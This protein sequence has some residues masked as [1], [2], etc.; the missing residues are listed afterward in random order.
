MVYLLWAKRAETNGKDLRNCPGGSWR[1][2]GTGS[3][4]KRDKRK[5]FLQEENKS[6]N[7]EEPE[8]FPKEIGSYGK[9]NYLVK[10]N[11]RN[12]NYSNNINY[13]ERTN[14]QNLID[15]YRNK[16]HAFENSFYKTVIL[17]SNLTYSFIYFENSNS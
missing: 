2:A 5:E 14:L 4:G 1:T 8:T 17:I 11:I 12:F 13:L 16:Y 3:A 6:R 7:F 9:K 10:N 15:V